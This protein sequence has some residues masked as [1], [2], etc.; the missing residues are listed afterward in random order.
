M[1]KLSLLILLC[2][3]GCVLNLGAQNV[4]P[5]SATGNSFRVLGNTKGSLKISMS[6]TNI[7]TMNVTTPQGVFTELGIEGFS[8]IYNSGK[9]QL[10]A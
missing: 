8:K 3:F 7:K 10:P 4:I 2:I 9:K 6:F 5:L 1:K